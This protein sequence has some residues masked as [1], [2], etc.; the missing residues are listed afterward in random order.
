MPVNKAALVRDT[1]TLEWLREQRACRYILEWFQ[2][3]FG[4]GCEINAAMIR[5]ALDPSEGL[6]FYVCLEWAV[7]RLL[8]PT[9][10]AAY[11]V[12]VGAIERDVRAKE[13]VTLDVLM[14]TEERL[15]RE[16]RARIGD[17]RDEVAYRQSY[18]L[19]F[20]L[21]RPAYDAHR[22]ATN[23]IR[24]AKQAAIVEALINIVDPPETSDAG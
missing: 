21:T 20:D 2:A 14:E 24:S 17:K 6:S 13:A 10:Q 22:R 11:D 1:I 19:W 4:E 18:N 16:H 23:A 5:R 12:A 9:A 3:T 7:D 15:Y 8:T